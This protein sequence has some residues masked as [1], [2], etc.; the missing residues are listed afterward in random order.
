MWIH[1]AHIHP[2]PHPHHECSHTRGDA[3]SV[4]R[5][6]LAATGGALHH[7]MKNRLRGNFAHCVEITRIPGPPTPLRIWSV[8]SGSVL[9]QTRQ[10]ILRGVKQ[11]SMRFVELSRKRRSEVPTR[12][13]CSAAIAQRRR[14]IRVCL[15]DIGSPSVVGKADPTTPA[16]VASAARTKTRT[17]TIAESMMNSHASDRA[18]FGRV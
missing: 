10:H 12:S 15:P 4:L 11:P 7:R 17:L 2:W 5:V 9:R 3:T 1:A 14:P 8:D 16:V 18:E 6:D 13:K